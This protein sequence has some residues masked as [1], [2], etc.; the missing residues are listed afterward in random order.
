MTNE[1]GKKQIGPWSDRVELS[2]TPRN[3][4]KLQKKGHVGVVS[5]YRWYHISVSNG[6]EVFDKAGKQL[7]KAQLR[8]MLKRMA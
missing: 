7:T 1:S 3:F 5:D 8:A 6:P 4:K 2:L